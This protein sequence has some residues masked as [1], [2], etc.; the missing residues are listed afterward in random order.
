[1][2][3]AIPIPSASDLLRAQAAN[4][5]LA[6]QRLLVACASLSPEEYHAPRQSFFGSIHA[7]L[8]H[9]VT[10]DERYLRRLNGTPQPP[11]HDDGITHPT[12][13]ALTRAF[14]ETGTRL[15]AYMA[16]LT[17]D[18]LSLEILLH[19]TERWGRAMEPVWQILQHVFAHGTHH[20]GQVHD[21]LSQTPVP[22]PQLDEFF[23][24]MDRMDRAAE[25]AALNLADWMIDGKG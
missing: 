6:N 22:P 1:M 3:P 13:D 25:V 18:D 14:H 17:P 19:E 24:R 10:T 8:D 23:L 20:R 7:T 12:R 9:I 21:M 2:P 4:H 11:T 5:L 15:L 16:P